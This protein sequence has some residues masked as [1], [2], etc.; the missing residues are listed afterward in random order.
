[1]LGAGPSSSSISRLP[2]SCEARDNVAGLRLCVC[3]C[4]YIY[5]SICVFLDVCIDLYIYIYIHTYGWFYGTG[6]QKMGVSMAAGSFL[7]CQ[8]W[9]VALLLYV[10][11]LQIRF[12]NEQVE[13]VLDVQLHSLGLLEAFG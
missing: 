9:H 4:I 8:L 2:E 7:A 1:M 10:A 11:G 5:V 6:S 12:V 3:V 13:H